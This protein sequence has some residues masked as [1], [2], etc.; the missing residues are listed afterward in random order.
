MLTKTIE[1]LTVKVS[2][3]G[4]FLATCHHKTATKTA[5]L[6]L[7]SP[8]ERLISLAKALT[9]GSEKH[10][11]RGREVK[12]P[13]KIRKSEGYPGCMQRVWDW[14]PQAD[15]RGDAILPIAV[16]AV[17]GKLLR[18]SLHTIN[19][20]ANNV[21]KLHAKPEPTPKKPYTTLNLPKK[22]L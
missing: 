17:P 10:F 2:A 16:F 11:S 6:M 19:Q 12:N 20:T 4:N 14:N 22:K 9:W 3:G 1:K 15:L 7:S 8:P 13:M 5:P 18:I 21:N